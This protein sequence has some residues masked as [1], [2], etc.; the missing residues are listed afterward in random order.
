VRHQT[1][2]QISKPQRPAINKTNSVVLIIDGCSENPDTL[3]L[4]IDLLDPAQ[5]YHDFQT[6]QSF[7][8]W[9]SHAQ[10]N[11]TEQLIGNLADRQIFLPKKFSEF[12]HFLEELGYK[13]VDH[14]PGLI[15]QYQSS[16][17]RLNLAHRVTFHK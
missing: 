8:T 7:R 16:R 13:V 6:L 14:E 5:L 3:V 9:V 4:A 15:N 10:I 11:Q 2:F 17:I 1:G 12:K